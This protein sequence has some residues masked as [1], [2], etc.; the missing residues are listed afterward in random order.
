MAK[1]N[2]DEAGE[3]FEKTLMSQQNERSTEHLEETEVKSL[4]KASGYEGSNDLH[5][6]PGY[7][8]LDPELFPTKGLFYEAESKFLIRAATVKEIRAFSVIND[9]DPWSVDEAINDI[10]KGCLIYRI[11]SKMMSFKD[12]KEDDRFYVVMHIRQLTFVKGENKIELKPLCTECGT[13][14]LIE[15][16]AELINATLPS[17]KMMSYYSEENKIFEVKTKSNGTIYVEPPSVGV[18]MQITAYI[19]KLQQEGKKPD[20]SFLKILPYMIKE[21]RGLTEKHIKDLEVEFI[22]WDATLFQT[23]NVIV[24]MAKVTISENINLTCSNCQAEVTTPINFP[25]G[26][27]SLFV[28][29][30]IDSELL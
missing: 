18:S 26:I 2:Y 20:A 14:N 5:F 28:I 27:R 1:Q 17:E 9:Q 8:E 15:L 7:I 21:W 3:A 16:K 6:I 13:Q 24:D 12:L 19:K 30:N 22:G 29:S 23:M 10:L 25:D 11:G 4:G